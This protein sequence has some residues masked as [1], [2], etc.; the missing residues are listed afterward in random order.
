MALSQAPL[1]SRLA[2]VDPIINDAITQQQVPGAVL[3]V[4]H[5]GQIVYRKAYGSRALVPRREPMTIDTI[6]D[7]ASLTKVVTTTTAVMQ[8]WEQGKFRMADPVAKYLPEFAQNGKQDITIRQLLTHYSGLPED[9][10]LTKKWEGNETAY[11]MAYAMVPER[12]PGSAFEYSD[13]NFIV[14]GALVEKLSSETLDQYAALHVFAPL[15]MKETRFLPPASW[16]PR[17][18]PTEED[19][20]HHLLHG[21][22]HD[23]TARFMGGVAGHAGVFTTA[24]DLARYARMMLNLGELDGARIFKPETVRMM[25]RV[26]TPPGMK[27]RRGFGWDI[28]SGYSRARGGHFPIGSYGHT[29]YTGIAFWIDPYSKTFFIFLSNRVHPDG[30]GNVLA[31]YRTVGTLAAEAVTDFDFNI[32][33][34]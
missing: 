10:D 7:C 32:L 12:P 14:L 1:D 21:V 19:E 6:F 28:D 8:L 34:H 33:Q 17:I 29:G 15:G 11:R 25:T 31:L 24:P 16:L 2:V 9:L 20:N 18:A 30:S 23:P 26:Q 13:I 22:V 3:I 4:G 27:D 5:D